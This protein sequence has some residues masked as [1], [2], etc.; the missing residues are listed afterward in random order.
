MK[1]RLIAACCLFLLCACS[2]TPPRASGS[3]ADGSF[4][5]D[6]GKP[7][8]PLFAPDCPVR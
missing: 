8:Q 7:V 4:H 1:T 2:A 6:I 3:L 5:Q